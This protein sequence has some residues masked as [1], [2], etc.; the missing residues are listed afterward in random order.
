MLLVYDMNTRHIQR[1][2]ILDVQYTDHPKFYYKSIAILQILMT[3]TMK[4]P[5]GLIFNTWFDFDELMLGVD[6][7][8]LQSSDK[9]Y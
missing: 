8:N 3:M 1:S 9:V 2:D 4:D 7:T 5:L 6:K